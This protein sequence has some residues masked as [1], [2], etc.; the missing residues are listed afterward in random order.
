MCLTGGSLQGRSN[1]N[2]DD[3]AEGERDTVEGVG[4]GAAVGVQ[5]SV[6][7]THG[8]STGVGGARRVDRDGGRST[9]RDYKAVKPTST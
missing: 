1:D 7:G 8:D 2:T 3:D 5:S 9:G 6:R 4:D